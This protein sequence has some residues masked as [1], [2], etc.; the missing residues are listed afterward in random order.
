MVN[1]G[2]GLL[3]ARDFE[4]LWEVHGSRCSFFC[5]VM[6]SYACW[7]LNPKPQIKF[8]GT[9]AKACPH[10]G[11]PS[12]KASW[13]SLSGSAAFDMV[14]RA[15]RS[16]RP[17]EDV[18]EDELEEESVSALWTASSGFSTWSHCLRGSSTFVTRRWSGILRVQHVVHCLKC[19]ITFVAR[20][21]VGILRL[22]RVVHYIRRSHCISLRWSQCRLV[23][24][25]GQ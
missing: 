8:F 17:G 25:Q 21:W 15:L 23:I 2:M 6:P 19:N 4:D 10:S 9:S 1:T 14:L 16:L 11:Q 3:W 20:R 12:T 22:Q 13:M 5:T 24:F 18:E 7:K